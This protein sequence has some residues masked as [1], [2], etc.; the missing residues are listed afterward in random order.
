MRVIVYSLNIP[1]FLR[2]LKILNLVVYAAPLLDYRG[3]QT[4]GFII[5]NFLGVVLV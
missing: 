2:D 5:R 3:F 4:H 1:D